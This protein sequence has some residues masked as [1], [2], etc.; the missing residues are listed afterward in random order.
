MNFAFT[1]NNKISKYIYA[2]IFVFVIFGIFIAPAFTVLTA[3]ADAIS[4]LSQFIP[5]AANAATTATAGGGT[6]CSVNPATWI[7]FAR[8]SA[9]ARPPFSTSRRRSASPGRM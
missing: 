1:K 3:H 4:G 2:G 8:S 6:T 7:G 9:E 5:M